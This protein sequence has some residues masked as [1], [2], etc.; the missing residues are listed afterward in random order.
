MGAGF[1][2]RIREKFGYNREPRHILTATI[3]QDDGSVALEAM[4]P[5]DVTHTVAVDWALEQS[6]QGVHVSQDEVLQM[7]AAWDEFEAD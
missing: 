6:Q 1:F 3:L 2:E 5:E 4:R 7:Q